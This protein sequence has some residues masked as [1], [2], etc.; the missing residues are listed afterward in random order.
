MVTLVTG[1]NGFIG[2][3]LCSRLVADGRRVRGS[4]RFFSNF[5]KSLDGVTV[6]DI[7]ATTDWTSALHG[8]Q[9][10][11]HLAAKVHATR[12]NGFSSLAEYRQTNVE[13]TVNLAR[14]AIAMGVERFVFLSSIKVHGEATDLG[15]PFSVTDS[16]N[17][18]GSYG[19]SKLEAEQ[20]LLD[21][22]ADTC[23]DVVIIRTPLVYGPKVKGNL[24]VLARCLALGV[25][26]P[27]AAVNNKRSFISLHNLVDL[28]STCLKSCAASNQTFLV[29]DGEDLSTTDLVKRMGTAL[30]FSPRMFYVPTPMLRLG[31]SLF[32]Q[33]RVYQ[34]LC[35]SLQLDSSRVCEILNWKPPVSVDKGMH[36]WLSGS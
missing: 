9:D 14:Q 33:R 21:V 5:S 31:L 8:V 28:I 36:F 19:L 24:D 30:G 27:L 34:R 35:C 15:R 3:A 26:L 7:S 6:G 32:G 22:A 29:S 18:A 16:P 4:F 17:P 12:D 20:A 23:M 13:A 25:P 10:I 1:A 11:V 2:S